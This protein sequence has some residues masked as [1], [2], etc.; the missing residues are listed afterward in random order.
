MEAKYSWLSQKSIRKISRK[1]IFVLCLSV[2][3]TKKFRMK[4]IIFDFLLAYSIY[5][6]EKLLRKVRY[7]L[8]EEFDIR[9]VSFIFLSCSSC[10]RF[11]LYLVCLYAIGFL[12]FLLRIYYSK[13]ITLHWRSCNWFF[14]GFRPQLGRFLKAFLPGAR[15]MLVMKL[16]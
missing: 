12:L 1:N 15:R 14:N 7:M 3:L 6:S 2:G 4:I 11:D 16:N 10:P 9:N 5:V 8:F 13:N